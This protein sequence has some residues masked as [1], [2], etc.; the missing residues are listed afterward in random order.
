MINKG[1]FMPSNDYTNNELRTLLNF[2]AGAGRVLSATTKDGKI[3]FEEITWLG[4]LVR[5]IKEKLG[6]KEALN[7][8]K[9]D[10]VAKMIK[11]FIEENKQNIN[12]KQAIR[13]RYQINSISHA[14]EGKTIYNHFRQPFDKLNTLMTT[15][16]W[17]GRGHY[18]F[19]EM[20]YKLE[21]LEKSKNSTFNL[22]SL[23][24]QIP[25][26][27]IK[28]F[29]FLCYY[30]EP[31]KKI[32]SYSSD[33][34]RLPSRADQLVDAMDKMVDIYNKKIDLFIKSGLLDSTK[35]VN[36]NIELIER[37]KKETNNIIQSFNTIEIEKLDENQ[38]NELSN[39]IESSK[40]TL[41]T[42]DLIKL[43]LENHR[44]KFQRV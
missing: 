26:D 19:R 18:V 25:R 4:R 40:I 21:N 3:H 33:S 44:K 11:D 32:D 2:Q 5:G 38:L 35:E 34:D 23:K 10:H 43:N 20:A 9:A 22:T 29:D 7:D 39:L 41:A 16:G 27:F 17:G 15:L 28:A 14:F 24:D 31:N 1:V 13:L 8:I 6:N 12:Y 36:A 42:L 30:M 37:L